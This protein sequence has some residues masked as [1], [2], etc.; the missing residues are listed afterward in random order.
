MNMIGQKEILDSITL[1]EYLIR[2]RE[3]TYL[4][5]VRGESLVSEGILPG[6]MLVVE[7]GREAKKGDLVLGYESDTVRILR[8]PNNSR[9]SFKIE[10]V[11]V[12]LIRKYK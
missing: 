10:A 8:I 6:D 5:S 7:R 4:V 12:A 11:V 2:N 9:T 1:D 3:A